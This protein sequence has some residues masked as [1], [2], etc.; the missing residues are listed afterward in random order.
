MAYINSIQ[1]YRTVDEFHVCKRQ[2][3]DKK[4]TKLGAEY[5]KERKDSKTEV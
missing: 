5:G 2:K 1:Y 3:N 4:K